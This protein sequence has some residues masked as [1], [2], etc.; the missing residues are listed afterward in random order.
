MMKTKEVLTQG[1][2]KIEFENKFY[3]IYHQKMKEYEFLALKQERMTIVEYER[4]LHDLSIFVPYH[5]PIEQHMI[6]KLQE[7]FRQDLQ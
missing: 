6:E 4:R 5:V 1:D 7:G 3:S 2:F